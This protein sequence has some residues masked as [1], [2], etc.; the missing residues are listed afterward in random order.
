MQTRSHE[1]PSRQFL[2]LFGLLA[3]FLTA[4]AQ[5]GGGVTIAPIPNQIIYVGG[6]AL[7]VPLE[8]TRPAGVVLTL[9]ASNSRGTQMPRITATPNGAAWMLSI[10]AP[11]ASETADVP[12]GNY[13]IRVSVLKAGTTNVLAQTSFLLTLLPA[14][15][16]GWHFLTDYSVL[17]KGLW[18]DL[19][20]NGFL[21]F[22]GLMAAGNSLFFERNFAGNFSS[23]N[24]LAVPLSVA[25]AVPADLDGDGR[26]D[27]FLLGNVTQPLFVNR[28]PKPS[29]SNPQLNLPITFTNVPLALT[30]TS[31]SG[32]AWADLDG[33][34]DLDLILV[35]PAVTAGLP[36]SSQQFRNDAGVLVA[37]PTTLP[38]ASGPVVVADFDGD[39]VADVLLFNT[40]VTHDVAVLLRNDGNGNFTDTGTSFPAGLVI[41]AG[42]SDFNGD[43][44]PDVWMQF[45]VG[46]LPT[47]PRATTELA[48]FQHTTG[49]FVETLRLPADVMRQAGTP[50]WGDFDNDGTPDFIAPMN[51]LTYPADK[52]TGRLRTNS[53]LTVWHNDGAGHFT[54]RGFVATNSPALT[55]VA[56]DVNGDGALDVALLGVYGLNG[57]YFTNPNR[58]AN[59]PPSMPG[60]LQAFS[61]GASLFF[62]WG[63][64]SDPNQTAPL[65]YNLR[66][67]TTPGGNEIVPSM[68]LG[69][70]TRQV[71]SPGNCAFA[72]SRL[73]KLPVTNVD[74]VYWSVQA[75]DNSFVGGPF[76]PEQTL[77]VD[78]PGNQPPVIAGLRNVFFGPNTEIFP[79]QFTVTDDRTRPEDIAISVVATN[80]QLFPS[81]TLAVTPDGDSIVK[82][83][84]RMLALR[85]A[86]GVVG[87]SDIS[88]TATDVNGLSTTVTFH[89]TS[90]APPPPAPPS[91]QLSLPAGGGPLR[92]NLKDAPAPGLNLEQSE[93]LLNWSPVTGWE[94]DSNSPPAFTLPRPVD[95]DRV[96]Y[97]LSTGE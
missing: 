18:A 83:P 34:G 82:L 66:V 61:F 4:F 23:N 63:D 88:V 13:S 64:A 80:L 57:G 28:T 8:V 72:G 53:S 56:G 90:M 21:D 91:L 93:D 68:S 67:G 30:Q 51:S 41:A 24:R 52:A 20:G 54:P 86:P 10:T 58:P 6:P 76:A 35:A 95:K 27:L 9:S 19:D 11:S 92:F 77:A 16:T 26:I 97:R 15:F 40:G 7:T 59:L 39:G 36:P 81:G 42:W 70:G 22:A 37:I 62:F 65:T 96:Y 87:E 84:E 12:L 74:S 43:G 50:A 75:V 48:L 89:V 73:I 47:Y 32:A 33:D 14:E 78:L 17:A 1:R 25:G 55:V 60:R 69:D 71:V 2:W 29:T 38:D 44:R 45:Q 79:V 94:F 49:G 5:S 46:N 3:S 85:P 31:H